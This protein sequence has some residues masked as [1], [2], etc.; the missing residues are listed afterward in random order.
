MRWTVGPAIIWFAINDPVT[1]IGEDFFAVQRTDLFFRVLDLPHVGAQRIA[2]DDSAISTSV[3]QR[4]FLGE[5]LRDCGFFAQL[6]FRAV[7][8]VDSFDHSSG[9]A[10][11]YK[12]S[13]ALKA[14][15]TPP[16]SGRG[17]L[18]RRLTLETLDPQSEEPRSLPQALWI[19]VGCR[20]A[21]TVVSGKVH[22]DYG[23]NSNAAL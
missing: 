17:V 20:H 5:L 18:R 1:W 9:R 13:K 6:V 21:Q 7:R 11:G 14:S 3:N 16:R 8:E 12:K 23:E 22:H 10:S 19:E 2:A 4:H 15:Q